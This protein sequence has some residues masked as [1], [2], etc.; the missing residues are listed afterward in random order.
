MKRKCLFCLLLFLALAGLAG[1]S[2]DDDD[3]N[4]ESSP[5]DDDASPNGDDDTGGDDDTSGDDDT[6][7]DDD[8]LTPDDDDD[9]DDNDDD[10]WISPTAWDD[11]QDAERQVELANFSTALVYYDD[12]IVKLEDDEPLNDGPVEPLTLERAEYGYVL[13]LTTLTLR[14][15]EYFL[16]G[17]LDGEDLAALMEE[18]LL[19]A[20]VDLDGQPTSLITVY[21]LELILPK[22]ELAC[23]RIDH[24]RSAPDFVYRMPPLRFVILDQA[25]EIPAT[26]GPDGRGEH[27]LAEAHLAAALLHLIYSSAL[28]VTGQN[29][30]TDASRIDDILEILMSGD[31]SE[32]LALLAEF[33]NLLTLHDDEVVDGPAFAALAHEHLR[34]ALESFHDDDDRDGVFFMNDNGTQMI[35]GDD[36]VDQGELADDFYD[37]WQLETDEQTA[38]ILRR[39]STGSLSLNIRANGEEIGGGLLLRLLNMAFTYLDDMVLA[40]IGRGVLGVY[41]PE[42]NGE[43]GLDDELAAG[44]STALTATTL[45]DASASFVP[46]ALVGAVLNPNTDQPM[47][48]EANVTFII[49]ANTGTTITTA[50]DMTAVAAA[51]DNYSV[52][53]GWID[54]RPIDISFLFQLLVGNFVP[55]DATVGFYPSQTYDVPFGLREI[56]PAWD[57]AAGN[58]DFYLFV[59]DET[60]TYTDVNGNGRYDPEVDTFTDADHAY[61]SYFHPADGAFQPYYFYFPDGTLAGLLPYGGAFAGADPTDCL[62]R[63]VSGI[64]MLAG[65]GR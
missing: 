8:D 35:P 64:L 54:D 24:A 63:I 48:T 36:F 1:C 39:T 28:V 2:G 10:T 49:T 60:E 27:D 33:P 52:G 65:G 59:V 3:D 51:G 17:W 29:L 31:F 9:D 40:E 45:S 5:T 15:I 46:G 38:D 42:T 34:I 11:F 55:A 43:N 61:D 37:A 58:P 19:E 62:N 4:N 50:G 53:D 16:A 25:L 26:T 14:I 21:L 56:L 41:P 23:E 44:V 12:C 20:G 6:G 30:D 18:Q 13:M 7:G 22:L 47:V 57:E 32:M